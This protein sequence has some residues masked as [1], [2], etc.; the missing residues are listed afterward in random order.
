MARGR[1]SVVVVCRKLG[2]IR[3]AS[4][5]CLPCSPRLPTPHP[6][7]D[8]TLGFTTPRTQTQPTAAPPS[9]YETVVE[10]R[11]YHH[12]P[13]PLHAS[14]PR[15]LMYGGYS[16]SPSPAPSSPPHIYSAGGAGAG[17]GGGVATPG[18]A[19]QPYAVNGV[20]SGPARYSLINKLQ[21]HA[22]Y[23]QTP[24]PPHHHVRL[25]HPRLLVP[26]C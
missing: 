15:L 8:C 24:T 13:P 23:G 14:A 1:G 11:Y 2:A 17:G 6:K 10:R 5:P 9:R 25:F 3:I 16:P 7:D 22:H 12:A 21:H 19:G 20:P 26:T 4:C 18:S